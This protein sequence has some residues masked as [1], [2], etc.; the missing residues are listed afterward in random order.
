MMPEFVTRAGH[1]RLVL[2]RP[3][4]N[5]GVVLALMAAFA[6][7]IL[8]CSERTSQTARARCDSLSSYGVG[9]GTAFAP[10]GSWR[11]PLKDHLAIFQRRRIASDELPQDDCTVINALELANDSE[12][13]SPPGK[14]LVDESRRALAG[15]PG[16]RSVFVFPTTKGGLCTV[17]TGDVGPYECGSGSDLPGTMY[18]NPE[19]GLP[20]LAAVLPNEMVAVRVKLPTAS[21]RIR[22]RQNVFFLQLPTEVSSFDIRL[23]GVYEDGTTQRLG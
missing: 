6:W 12:L 23:I 16:G 13:S 21:Y 17:V 11:A 5:R 4:T 22:V 9:G 14:P 18:M 19:P 3:L 8:G 20:L 10:R 7:P 2:A 15:L 1:V